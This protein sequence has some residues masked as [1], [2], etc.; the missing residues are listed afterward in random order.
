M[1][2]VRFRPNFKGAKRTRLD[3]I[4]SDSISSFEL[5]S[6]SF[7]SLSSSSNL[8]LSS[9]PSNVSNVNSS[10]SLYVVLEKGSK[11]SRDRWN[12]LQI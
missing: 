6:T 12:F 2:G 8:N 11:I 9:T 4:D 1:A 7:P 3:I 10:R 5:N